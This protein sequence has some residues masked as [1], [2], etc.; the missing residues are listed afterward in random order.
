MVNLLGF[1]ILENCM[2]IL[3][4]ACGQKYDMAI[5]TSLV[6]EQ[7]TVFGGNQ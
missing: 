3:I 2:E 6:A 7:K 1:Q 5:Q 4:V